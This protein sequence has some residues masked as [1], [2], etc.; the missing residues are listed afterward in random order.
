[1]IAMAA[2]RQGQINEFNARLA[3]IYCKVYSIAPKKIHVRSF[4]FWKL[5]V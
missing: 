4:V 3:D 1:M 5:E 2:I